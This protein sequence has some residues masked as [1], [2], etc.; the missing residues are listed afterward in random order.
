MT[1][2]S[3]RRPPSLHFTF[4]SNETS[5]TSSDQEDSREDS[6]M[7]SNSDCHSRPLSVTIPHGQ[8]G[9]RRPTLAEVLS[10]EAPAPYTLSAFMAYLSQNHCLETLEFTMDAKRYRKHFES[11]SSSA[12]GGSPITPTSDSCQYVRMLWQRLMDAYIQQNGPREVNVPCGVREQLLSLPNTYYPPPPETLDSAVNIV[13]EL[14]EESILLPFL[15]SCQSTLSQTTPQYPAPWERDHDEAYMRGSLDER[16]LYRSR[17]ESSSPPPLDYISSSYS[18]ATSTSS[19]GYHPRGMVSPFSPT[20][21][22]HRHSAQT[23]PST[24]SGSN[25]SMIIEED[26]RLALADS[27]MTPPNTPPSCE[28]TGSSPKNRSDKTWKKMTGKLSW[29]KSKRSQIH[30]ALLSGTRPAQD[31]YMH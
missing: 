2:R 12:A 31:S 21:G 29:S 18:S 11:M 1:I 13:H 14:M 27:P 23:A 5:P 8:F 17:R 16:M 30:P 28:S 7:S 9:V 26:H 3:F 20:L 15:N 10:N 25:D 19:A 6:D 4:H 22:W 24:W